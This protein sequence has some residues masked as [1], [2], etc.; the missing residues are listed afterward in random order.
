[1]YPTASFSQWLHLPLLQ[2]SIKTGKLTLVVC[3]CVQFYVTLSSV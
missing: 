1:M 2:F 3:V